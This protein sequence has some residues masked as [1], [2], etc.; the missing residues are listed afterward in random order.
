VV[1]IMFG[2]GIKHRLLSTRRGGREV[3][4]NLLNKDIKYTSATP[5]KMPKD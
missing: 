5:M 2:D 4:P 1:E 3:R